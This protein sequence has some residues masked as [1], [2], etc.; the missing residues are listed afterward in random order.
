MWTHTESNTAL[1]AD[2]PFSLNNISY[3][4]GWLRTAQEEEKTALGLK[5]IVPEPAPVVRAPIDREKANGI[6]RAK[7]T[8]WKLL[9][10]SDWRELPNKNMPEDWASYRAA[11]V[12]ECQRLEGEYNAAATYTDFELIK[13]EW[14]LDP[15]TQAEL[16]RIESEEA[17]A[18]GGKQD[19]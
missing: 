18:E 16:D 11:V 2:K 4:A 8:A 5:W 15:I 7:D 10:P 3:P 6:A 14:P 9:H 19:G 13:Q 17:A 12:A 1:P